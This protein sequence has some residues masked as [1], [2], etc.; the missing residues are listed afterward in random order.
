MA[1][2]PP[3]NLFSDIPAALPAEF[4]QRMAGGKG[5][6]IERIV[7]RGHA[8]P[9]GFWYDQA[10]T[11]WVVLVKGSACIRFEEG[12]ETVEM[13]VGDHLVIPPR[14]RHRIEWTA[15]DED[16]VWIAVFY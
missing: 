7:S 8:S 14:A 13:K 9:E 5:V 15:R 11:E 12:G 3:K 1:M 4:V 6:R 2:P 16:T 10:E